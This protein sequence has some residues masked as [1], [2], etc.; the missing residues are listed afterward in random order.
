MREQSF[1]YRQIALSFLFLAVCSTAAVAQEKEQGLLEFSLEEL[2][3]VRIK[4]ATKTATALSQNPNIIT[5]IPYSQIQ[6]SGAR[7]LPELLRFVPGVNVRWNPMMQTIDVRGFGATPF[8]SRVLLLID[9]VPYNSW[10]KGGFPQQPGLDFFVLQN[11]KQIEVIRGS[12]SALYGENAFWGI[13]NIVTLSGEDLNGGTAEVYI[14][15]RHTRSTGVRYGK[16]FQGGSIFLS[17]KYLQSQ[18]PLEFWYEENDSKVKGA[19]I[20]LKGKY[21]GFELAYFLHDDE[22]DG[23]SEPIPDPQL[24]AGTV[25]Q[26]A[27]KIEQT[28]N[29]ASLKY[30]YT[31]EDKPFSFA[32]DISAAKRTGAHCAA[33]HAAQQDDHF[34]EKEPHGSQIIGDF[35]FGFQLPKNK[36]LLGAEVRRVDAGDH[37][38]E[39][40]G[41]PDVQDDVKITHAYN[42]S[43][44]YLQDQ[45]SLFENRMNLVAGL[46]YDAKTSPSLWNDRLSPRIAAIVQPAPKLFLRGGWSKAFH[47]PDFSNLYQNSWFFTASAGNLAFPLATFAPNPQ[48]KPEEIEN[49]DAGIEYQFNKNLSARLN[50][51]RS[52]LEDF[53]VLVFNS[54]PA[55]E[56][57]GVQYE[58]HPDKA[59]ILGAEFELQWTFSSKMRGFINWAYQQESQNN[60]LKDSAG[61]PFEFVYAP[62]HKVNLSAFLGPFSGLRSA[63]ELAWRDQYTAPAFWYLVNSGFTDPTV[64]ALDSYAY[65]NARFSYDLPLRVGTQKNPL[66]IK[67]YCRN[68]LDERPRETLVGVNTTVAGREFF[69]GIEFTF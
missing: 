3:N 24:P 27:D 65:L 39:L 36:I 53:I 2:L 49:F 13:I 18:Y 20:F 29:I 67:F 54:P 21:K 23:F 57:P 25:F 68:L 19:D 34:T 55:P 31:P 60:N 69:G 64:R 35:R 14:G 7:T 47:F 61:Q 10:N 38:D 42:K 5:V 17:A 28:I 59:I 62:K 48:L 44:I 11:V 43:A 46:R 1:C 40:L 8:T 33:C 51:F 63:I 56:V 12:G 50:L 4:S 58:N 6:E 52:K 41:Q 9:G 30:E 15:E 26:S 16:A 45:I 32:G 22:T 37:A 66:R